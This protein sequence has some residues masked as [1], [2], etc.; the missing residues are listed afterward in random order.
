M[1]FTPLLLVIALVSVG[2]L[3]SAQKSS[4]SGLSS[5][6]SLMGKEDRDGGKHDDDGGK[7]DNDGGKHDGDGG[8]GHGGGP[9]CTPEPISMIGLGIAG[10]GLLRARLKKTA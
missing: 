3:A 8:R 1:K 7:R 10:L 9:Q 6:P 2:A 4:I 5:Y